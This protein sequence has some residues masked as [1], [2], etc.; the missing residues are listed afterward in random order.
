MPDGEYSTYMVLEIG[1]FVRVHQK[2]RFSMELGLHA[3]MVNAPKNR[4]VQVPTGPNLSQFQRQR[5]QIFC[6]CSQS[7]LIAWH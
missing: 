5:R 7:G 4:K 3:T 6:P 2:K 1:A